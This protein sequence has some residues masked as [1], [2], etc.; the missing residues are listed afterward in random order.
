MK[1]LGTL[2]EFYAHAL[3]IER[4]AAARYAELHLWFKDGG[5]D[6]LAGLCGNL[7]QAE[8]KHLKALERRCHGLDIPAID[9]S[10]YRWTGAGSP[11]AP[12]LDVLRQ[13]TS[14]GELVSIALG[15]ERSAAAFFEWVA[16]TSPDARV[17]ALALELAAE[18]EEHIRWLRDALEYQAH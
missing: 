3:A 2:E 5:E 18:E 16:A 4:E 1:P 15:A 6:V 8:R 10:G 14:V 9:A 12:G 17:R 11:E 7:A 13:V